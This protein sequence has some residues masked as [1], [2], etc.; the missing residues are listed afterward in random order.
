[1]AIKRKFFEFPLPGGARKV[2]VP[3]YY[4][5]INTLLGVTESSDDSN[6]PTGK[7][8]ELYFDGLLIKLTVSCKVANKYRRTSFYCPITTASTAL[9]KLEG[10]RFGKNLAGGEAEII[11]AYQARQRRFRY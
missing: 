3:D 7:A 11:N 10:K 1:M 9:A 4:D 2:K 6:T 5:E 8:E